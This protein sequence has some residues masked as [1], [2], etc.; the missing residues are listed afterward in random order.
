[1]V[2]EHVP[3]RAAGAA[4]IGSRSTEAPANRIRAILVSVRDL[5]PA[6]ADFG[7]VERWAE[8]DVQRDPLLTGHDAGQNLHRN[9]GQQLFCWKTTAAPKTKRHCR[10]E[11]TAR[12][13]SDGK[14]HRE[15]CQTKCQRHPQQPDAN[16]GKSGR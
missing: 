6:A 13:V 8:R 11:V 16:I 3:L 2:D 4:E 12:Y 5:F 10:V 14:G 9:V 15:D 7:T 1:M